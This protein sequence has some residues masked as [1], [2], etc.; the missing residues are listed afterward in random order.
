M[1]SLVKSYKVETWP[2]WSPHVLNVVVCPVRGDEAHECSYMMAL[3]HFKTGKSIQIH[4]AEG[5][6][7]FLTVG[8]SWSS[9]KGSVI[10]VT[11]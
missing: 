7:W 3:L 8:E 1:E 10:P 11:I 4:S 9:G 6:M 2:Q 5:V